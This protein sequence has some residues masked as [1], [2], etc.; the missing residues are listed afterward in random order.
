MLQGPWQEI[1]IDIIGLLLQLKE[2]DAVMVVIHKDDIAQDNNNNG[3][4]IRNC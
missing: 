3:V 4:I 2:K 1:S